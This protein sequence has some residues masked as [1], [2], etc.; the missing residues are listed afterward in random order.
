M[1]SGMAFPWFMDSR[2][3]RHALPTAIA[4]TW[5]VSYPRHDR[6][7]VYQARTI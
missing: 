7:H 5:F 6:P 2:H 1:S 4:S 3:R